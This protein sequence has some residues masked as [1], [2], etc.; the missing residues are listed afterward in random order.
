MPR[1]LNERRHSAGSEGTT[2][3]GRR[4]TYE[5]KWFAVRVRERDFD[6]QKRIS[7]KRDRVGEDRPAFPK[8]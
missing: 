1:G 3:E 6:Q 4:D 8:V 5:L 2:A 7:G